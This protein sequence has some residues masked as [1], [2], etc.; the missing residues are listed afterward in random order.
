MLTLLLTVLVL[1]VIAYAV[2][3]MPVPEPFR[4]VAF[5]IIVIYLLIIVFRALGVNLPSLG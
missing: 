1:G 2:Q 3:V 5:C 4:V